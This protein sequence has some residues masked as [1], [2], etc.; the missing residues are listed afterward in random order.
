M[1]RRN[2]WKSLLEMANEDLERYKSKINVEK[3]DDGYYSVT[4]NNCEFA[5]N[6]FEDELYDLIN[7]A[8][9]NARIKAVKDAEQAALRE[10]LI[11]FRILNG[12]TAQACSLIS[13]DLYFHDFDTDWIEK[14]APESIGE[15]ADRNG[16]FCV[17]ESDYEI[18]EQQFYEQN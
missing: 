8:W 3:D 15:Y 9:S 14:V 2:D 7:D 16:E 18:A 11:T 5:D 13:V 12:M 6:N 4:I 17:H 10:K 1:N